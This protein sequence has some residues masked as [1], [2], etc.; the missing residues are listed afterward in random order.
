MSAHLVQQVGQKCRIMDAVL[1]YGDSKLLATDVKLLEGPCWLNDQ[2]R[3]HSRPITGRTRPAA[4][5]PVP[6]GRPLPD[7][8]SRQDL[9]PA[10]TLQLIGFYF[11]FLLR[12]AHPPAQS[13]GLLLIPGNSTYL[14]ANLGP[15]AGPAAVLE[16]LGF[17]AARLALFAVNDNPDVTEA[18]GGSHW[19]LLAYCAAD[20]TF[21]HYDSLAGTNRRAAQRVFAAAKRPESKL[22]EQATP[23][24]ENGYDCGMYVLALARLLCQRHACDGEGMSWTV[25]LDALA[26]GDVAALRQE[27]LHLI[28]A[29]A[30]AAQQEASAAAAEPV[31]PAPPAPPQ[32]AAA[33]SPGLEPAEPAPRARKPRAR[34]ACSDLSD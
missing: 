31:A 9:P 23:Q 17:S 8:C 28:Q 20:D 26:P 27:V 25:T 16:P 24:Q 13:P 12:E 22:W 29:K 2:A 5:P 3:E 1:S 10:P 7:H 34:P 15:E 33:A 30:A 19:S 14:L 6:L 32:E 4:A 21:R 18:F 11:E